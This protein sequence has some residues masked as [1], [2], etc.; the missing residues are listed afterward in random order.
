MKRLIQKSFVICGLLALL[1]CAGDH[2]V[3]AHPDVTIQ[4]VDGESDLYAWLEKTV[5]DRFNAHG[6]FEDGSY[7][8]IQDA[9]VKA[10][11]SKGYYQPHVQ[12]IEPSPE[13][14]KQTP[15]LDIAPGERYTIS[16]ITVTGEPKADV[17]LIKTGEALDATSVLQ[18]QA[19]LADDIQVDACPY[20][21]ELRHE[22]VLNHATHTGSVTYFISS[23]RAAVFGTTTF[24]GAPEIERGYL[25]RFIKYTEGDCWGYSKIEQTKTALL[26]TGLLSVVRDVLPETPE[27]DGQVDIVFEIKKRAPRSVRLGANYYTDQ[28]PGIVA[29][30]EHR[31]IMGEGEK[32]SAR[33]KSNFLEQ[34]LEGEFEKPYFW[35]DNKT[36]TINNRLGRIDSDAYIENSLS[37]GVNIKNDFNKNLSATLGTAIELTRIEDKND[38]NEESTFGLFST[39]GLVTYDNRDNPLNPHEGWRLQG[40][41]EP[42]FDVLG[43]ASPFVKTSLTASTYLEL[44]EKKDIVLA[45]RGK[46]GGILGGGTDS[47][48][49]SKRFYAGGGG[50][51]RGFGYQE[52]GPM[53]DGDPTGGRSVVETSAEL[54]F[55]FTENMG[56]AVFVDGGGA[57]DATFPDFQEG[58]YIGAGAGFRYFT[59]FGPLRVDFAVPVNKRDQTDAAFQFYISIGQAF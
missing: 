59:G 32:L 23:G 43:E 46:L 12:F 24:E 54:R 33:L 37:A 19:A 3:Q 2:P 14:K 38:N 58:Y 1:L 27:A 25:E 36:L 13:D 8:G 47:V 6:F 11:K 22:V 9:T 30:W 28:G 45:L 41:G 31:N 5:L 50:S 51:I 57:Y 7:E 35:T 20:N 15:V 40:R 21:L 48:P 4:G 44:S 42:F 55:K 52:A 17:R 53:E 26:E 16:S 39:P 10:L 18:A 29:E 34:S 56:G 49:A